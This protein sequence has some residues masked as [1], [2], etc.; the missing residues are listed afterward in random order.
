ML[1]ARLRRLIDPPL[2]RLCR[3]LAA[4]GLSADAVTIAGFVIGGTCFAHCA[5]FPSH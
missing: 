4:R 2:E 3:P 1:D 5:A